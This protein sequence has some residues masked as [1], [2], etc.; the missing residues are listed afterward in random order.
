[1]TSDMS[2]SSRHTDPLNLW[3][4][5]SIIFEHVHPSFAPPKHFVFIFFHILLVMFN[6]W[7]QKNNKKGII[8]DLVCFQSTHPDEWRRCSWVEKLEKQAE[9]RSLGWEKEKERIK[10]QQEG[11]KSNRWWEKGPERGCG[12]NNR[13]LLWDV[14][15]VALKLLVNRCVTMLMTDCCFLLWTVVKQVSS[16]EVNKSCGWIRGPD[17]HYSHT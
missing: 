15:W 11:G 10:R 8:Y 14:S 16:C 12:R 2:Y 5:H 9:R 3:N 4:A 1:M 7:L 17:G 13:E 6:Y